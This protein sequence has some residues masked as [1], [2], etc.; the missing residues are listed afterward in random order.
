MS[1]IRAEKGFMRE[2]YELSGPCASEAPRTK[3]CGAGNGA[4][5]ERTRNRR[6]LSMVIR[7]IISSV[8]PALR[9]FGTNT[10]SVIPYPGRAA[11][12]AVKL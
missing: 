11:L 10:V 6:G 9:S 12:R 2:V 4:R 8:T 3:D 1:A 5:Q 7:R